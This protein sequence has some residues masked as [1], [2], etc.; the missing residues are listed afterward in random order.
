MVD[1]GCVLE[2]L[3][4]GR[5]TSWTRRVRAVVSDAGDLELESLQCGYDS[6]RQVLVKEQSGP[7]PP[8]RHPG[9]EVLSGGK[10]QFVI[11]SLLHLHG[12]QAVVVA[13]IGKI[14]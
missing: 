6:P 12:R 10:L 8:R 5:P 2:N 1:G 13:Q 3:F 11:D 14:V 4:V 9:V 7:Y